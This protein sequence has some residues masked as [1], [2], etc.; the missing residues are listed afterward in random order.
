M[1]RYSLINDLVKVSL[2]HS[3]SS[4]TLIT[5]FLLSLL[6]ISLPG[7]LKIPFSP[8]PLILKVG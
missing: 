8:L 4:Y 6:R 5:S 3:L 7:P 1:F 2:P